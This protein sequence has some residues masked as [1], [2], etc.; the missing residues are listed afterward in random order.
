MPQQPFPLTALACKQMPKETLAIPFRK[1][2]LKPLNLTSLDNTKPPQRQHWLPPASRPPRG[3][4][5]R[6][7]QR[8][9]LQS[10]KPQSFSGPQVD[11]GPTRQDHQLFHEVV[12][13]LEAKMLLCTKKSD[14]YKLWIRNI[15]GCCRRRRFPHLAVQTQ[16]DSLLRC[17]GLHMRVASRRGAPKS[18]GDNGFADASYAHFCK[19][20]LSA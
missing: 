1:A 14:M 19:L 11:R 20:L 12:R 10:P 15:L 17:F 4:S 7:P 5:D 3:S 2:P 6:G 13:D 16:T 18:K 9:M 8:R